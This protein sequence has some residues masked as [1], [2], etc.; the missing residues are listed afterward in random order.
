MMVK[1]TGSVNDGKED[2]TEGKASC[3]IVFRKYST[4]DVTCCSFD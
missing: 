1:R 4:C 3:E 2:Y